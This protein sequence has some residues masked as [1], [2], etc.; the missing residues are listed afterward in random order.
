MIGVSSSSYHRYENNNFGKSFDK[1][2][3][4]KLRSISRNFSIAIF[5]DYIISRKSKTI[6]FN[7]KTVKIDY[8]KVLRELLLLVY[9]DSGYYNS[10]N[11]NK[12][13]SIT[14]DNKTEFEEF[15]YYLFVLFI[16]YEENLNI[17]SS[18]KEE[19]K[20]KNGNKSIENNLVKLKKESQ[21]K[22]VSLGLSLLDEDE[23]AFDKVFVY[24]KI[25]RYDYFDIEGGDYYTYRCLEVENT[26]SK[27]TNYLVHREYCEEKI[28]F[29]EMNIR[30]FTNDLSK[31]SL[32]I[33][34]TNPIQPCIVQTFRIKL[35]VSLKKGEKLK[36]YLRFKCMGEVKSFPE[37]EPFNTSISLLRYKKG[38]DYLAMGVLFRYNMSQVFLDEIDHD[39]NMIK[40]NICHSD[41]D[42]EKLKEFREVFEETNL[43]LKGFTFRINEPNKIGYRIHFTYKK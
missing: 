37:N 10:E 16:G 23:S 4:F 2:I 27:K 3:L 42:E 30:A 5:E 13:K 9:K 32:V 17:K 15:I 11:Y 6:S 31:E 19:R 34:N 12:L 18:K 33:E 35:P 21:I 20:V 1:N 29:K 26:S 14:I 7:K 38:I 24:H 43:D 22:R 8:V 39:Y 41:L 28:D 25:Y 40:S 36:V